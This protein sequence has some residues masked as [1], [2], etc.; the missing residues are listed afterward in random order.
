MRLDPGEKFSLWL[1]GILVILVIILG[2]A[3]C[4]HERKPTSS[5]DLLTDS[6]HSLDR[7]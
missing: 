1:T 5:R 3:S 6:W 2:I 7:E 4:Y